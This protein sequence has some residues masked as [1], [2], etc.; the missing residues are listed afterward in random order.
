MRRDSKICTLYD[1]KHQAGFAF[2]LYLDTAPH[3][4]LVELALGHLGEDLVHGV[5]GHVVLVVVVQQ[6]SAVVQELPVK[7]VV[8][9]VDLTDHVEEVQE[10]EECEQEGVSCVAALHPP[11]AGHQPG[12]PLVL[13]LDRELQQPRGQEP[14]PPALN[15]G[16]EEAGQE[17][18]ESLEEN[19]NKAYERFYVLIIILF[20]VLRTH[21]SPFL[22]LL[23]NIKSYFYQEIYHNNVRQRF[24]GIKPCDLI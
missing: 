3:A 23:F 20:F 17:E 16:P 13:V 11:E 18:G 22:E 7:K 10:L 14:Q 2:A 21:T 5:P 9:Q 24:K 1:K 19:M 8:G 6:P 12:Q 4:M 15:P